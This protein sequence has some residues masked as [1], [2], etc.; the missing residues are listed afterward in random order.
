MNL[1]RALL[2]A[3]CLLPSVAGTAAAQQEASCISDFAKLRDDARE[4][5]DAIRA[6]SARRA[7]PQEACQLFNEFSA[8]ETKMLKYAF[9][10]TGR[11]AIPPQVIET[12]KQSVAHT[13]EI[14]TKVCQAAAAP[15]I[16]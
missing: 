14:R 3:V 12:L 6:A 9:D 16:R 4:K 11:C 2:I 5:A 15:P 1:R 7:S 8:A 13:A 10:T